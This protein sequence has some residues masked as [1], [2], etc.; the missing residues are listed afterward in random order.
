MEQ[1][2][3]LWRAKRKRQEP[4]QVSN[5]TILE[6]TQ[7]ESR[8]EIGAIA[9]DRTTTCVQ[10]KNKIRNECVHKRKGLR[11]IAWTQK[12]QTN[13]SALKQSWRLRWLASSK[14]YLHKT[15]MKYKHLLTDKIGSRWANTRRAELTSEQTPA[16]QPG[17]ES[18]SEHPPCQVRAVLSNALYHFHVRNK[19]KSTTQQRS[20]S[21]KFIQTVTAIR[22]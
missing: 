8:K 11:T 12:V 21:P 14:G 5:R 7:N 10:K 17:W 18:L 16:Y 6:Q 1:I 22:D 19:C 2:R 13:V 15:L 9:F 3:T 4:N 20:S